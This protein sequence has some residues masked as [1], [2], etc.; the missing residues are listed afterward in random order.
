MPAVATSPD[1]PAVVVNEL[2]THYGS[3]QILKG[4]SLA[5]QRGEIMVIMG[6]SGSP[7]A[8]AG[9][10]SVLRARHPLPWLQEAPGEG[11]PTGAPTYRRKD[12]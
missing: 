1:A 4:A 8:S 9:R 5:V 2:V 3:R 6:G 12:L 7:A 11:C 10:L